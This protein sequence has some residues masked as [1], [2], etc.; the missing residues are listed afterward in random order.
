MARGLPQAHLPDAFARKI[1]S[2]AY[3]HLFS[4]LQIG[5][6][7]LRNRVVHASMSTRYVSGGQVT[8]RLITYHANRARGGAAMLVTEPLNLLPRQTNPQKVRVLDPANRGGLE[9]WAAAVRSFDSH[10]IAQIQDPGRGRHQPGRVHDAVG[11]SPLPDDLSW[12]VPH[13]LD[14]GEVE[15]MI[16]DFAKAARLLRDCGFSGVE[17]SAGHGHL[18]H[19]FLAARSN[20]RTDRFGGEL[21]G[22]ARFVTELC[23]ALRAE[24]GPD[25]LVGVKLPGEDG[26][27]GGIGLE[28]S[29]AVTR[30]VHATGAAS[31]LTWCW[32]SHSDTLDWHLP[33]MHGPRAPYVDR[34]ATLARNAPGTVVGA[35]GLITDP[36]EGERFVRDG[37]ADLVM[38]GRPLVT[39]PAWGIKAEQGREAQIR[40]CVSC[41]T[42]WGA[43]VGGSTLS[44]DNN[45]RVGLVDEVDWKP[46]AAPRRKR[47]VVVGAG[48]AGM[49]AAWVAAARGH[50]VTVFSASGEV[51]GKT[52]LQAL[53]PGGESLSS[54]YDYQRLCADRAG[55]RFEFGVRATAAD[56]LALQ[57]DAVVLACGA[58]PAWPGFLPEE[59]RGEGVFNDVRDTAAALV[60]R[61]SRESG[62]ALLYDRDHTAFT[63]A[64]AELLLER[65]ERV[66]LVTP[67]GGL[68]AEEPLVNRQGIYRRLY[69]KGVEVYTL[70][71]PEFGDEFADGIVRLRHVLG[72]RDAEVDGVAL[73]TYATA[74]IPDDSLAAP[75][76]AAGVDVH[77]IGDCF[78]PRSLLV[79]SGEGYAA[80][81]RL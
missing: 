17:I 9:R 73:L 72:G 62:T 40:Y 59:Y 6:V 11:P 28:E 26:M 25:F 63:Y 10:L 33:D 44:C 45:P 12:T 70:F 42:C 64:T 4:P 76:R 51:G 74:R 49:E 61:R 58:T 14:T 16:V 53:L 66:A 29:A 7:R 57:P 1:V 38:L 13:A 22:R 24:C 60:A 35:L 5:G 23:S 56:V 39:D 75:L 78:A 47:V 41:N 27:P 2:T 19:Q 65:F 67:R 46:A 34:I 48:V 77:V 81:M 69:G 31:Y 15:Q 8:D 50:E 68:A 80:G 3:P 18:F 37:L 20:L 52:R 54:I 71:E 21:E 32:G 43:I 36:N 79:A 55:A 30:L